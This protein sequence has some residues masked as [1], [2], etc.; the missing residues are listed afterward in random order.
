MKDESVKLFPE[1]E[2]I[3]ATELLALTLQYT[4]P[5]A[6]AINTEK[7]Q[8][9]LIIAPIILDIKRRSNNSISLFS[10]IEFNVLPIN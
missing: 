4:I 9:E 2:P 5:L 1:I 6:T 8:S 3:P 10:G 7:A